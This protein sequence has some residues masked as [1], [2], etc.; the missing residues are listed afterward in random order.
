[1]KVV[2]ASVALRWPLEEPPG[3]SAGALADHLSGRQ[4]LVAPELLRYEVGNVLVNKSSLPFDDAADLFNR[5]LELEIQAYTLGVEE[6][7]E[8]LLLAS[9]FG[10]P[11]YDASY[12]AL[13]LALNVR[14][15]TADR[16]LATRAK[17]LGI[18]DIV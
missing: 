8:S 11:A 13:S 7:R 10:I 2:D 9:R 18:I 5:F 1:M 14:L 4:V 16:K 12:L 15:V 3:G 17:S 6:H